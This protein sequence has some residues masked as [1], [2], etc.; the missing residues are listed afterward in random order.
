MVIRF[1]S[2]YSLAACV[3][4]AVS[5]SKKAVSA[6]AAAVVGV[7]LFFSPIESVQAQTGMPEVTHL[8]LLASQTA[9]YVVT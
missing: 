6:V 2:F 9:P 4:A 3:A 1:F 5:Q 7:G 8:Y